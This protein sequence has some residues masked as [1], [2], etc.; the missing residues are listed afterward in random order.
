MK[1]KRLLTLFAIIS[2]CFLAS[3]LR[4]DLSRTLVAMSRFGRIAG[5]R[6]TLAPHREGIT[7]KQDNHVQ[8]GNGSF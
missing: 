6:F 4:V 7:A 8:L 2:L 5:W 3:L 1:P